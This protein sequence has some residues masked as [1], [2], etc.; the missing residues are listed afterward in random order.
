MAERMLCDQRPCG[1]ES[2]RGIDERQW[3]DGVI[4]LERLMFGFDQ[5]MAWLCCRPREMACFE[6]IRCGENDGIDRERWKSLFATL[7]KYTMSLEE[8][9]AHRGCDV[10]NRRLG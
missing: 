6:P 3:H 7:R 10:P 9:R 2:S 5:N 1:L 8:T 4:S